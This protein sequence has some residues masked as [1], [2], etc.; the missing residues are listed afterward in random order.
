[1]RYLFPQELKEDRLSAL[2]I[3]YE[4]VVAAADVV[5]S[6]PG[7]GIVTDVI[8]GGTRL[9]YT[10]RGDFPE[11]PILVREMEPWVAAVY[12]PSAQVREGRVREA[13][14]QALALSIPPPPD[15][16]GADRAAERILQRLQ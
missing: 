9:V 8:A 1:M 12:L 3:R 7:Y 4:D 16:G 14:H 5:I 15:L 11:Y 13:V 2:S 6:K 10:D